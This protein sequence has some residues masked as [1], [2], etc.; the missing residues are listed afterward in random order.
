MLTPN[1][2]ER[3]RPVTA[4]SIRSFKPILRQLLRLIWN[5]AWSEEDMY[6]M[7]RTAPQNCLQLSKLGHLVFNRVRALCSY[8]SQGRLD[9]S[10]KQHQD[11]T[12][13]ETYVALLSTVYCHV[14]IHGSMLGGERLAVSWRDN[15]QR[16]RAQRRMRSLMRR[17]RRMWK[18]RRRRKRRRKR[19]RTEKRSRKPS[20]W[21][22][23]VAADNLSSMNLAL[24]AISWANTCCMCQSCHGETV[25]TKILYVCNADLGVILKDDIQDHILTN[26]G[27]IRDDSKSSLC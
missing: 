25:N 8:Y 17:G 21:P 23:A 3:P 20:S 13:E 4:S 18:S 27:G 9:L 19:D 15:S 24:K 26:I 6:L 1:I 5:K 14:S 11:V 22:A 7:K 10:A 16:G 12:W 2:E